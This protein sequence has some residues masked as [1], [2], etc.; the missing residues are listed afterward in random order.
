MINIPNI[1]KNKSHDPNHQPDTESARNLALGPE[2]QD[3][4][5]FVLFHENDQTGSPGPLGDALC[6]MSKSGFPLPMAKACA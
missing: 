1:Y 3:M 2:G 4:F 6:Q 5:T